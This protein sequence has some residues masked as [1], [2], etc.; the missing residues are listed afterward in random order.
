MPVHFF[1]A[2]RRIFRIL[3]YSGNGNIDIRHVPGRTD[4]FASTSVSTSLTTT[5][6][7]RFDCELTVEM[8]VGLGTDILSCLAGLASIGVGDGDGSNPVGDDGER[9]GG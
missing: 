1:L 4:S 6:I 9:A 2:A 5:E 3:D 8:G 7:D